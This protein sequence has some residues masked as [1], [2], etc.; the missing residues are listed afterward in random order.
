M[1]QILL[2]SDVHVSKHKDSLK[3]LQ[4]CLDALK[5]V[6]ETAVEKDI[7]NVVFLGDLFQDREKIQVL[8]YQRAY[9]VLA[10]YCGGD[11]PP[12][13]LYMII[14]NH[15]MWFLDKTNI[16]SV[17]PF[18]AL[19]GVRI[20]SEC[21]TINIAGLNIDFLPF[22]LN[23]LNSLESFVEG[24]SSVLCGHIALDGAQLNT[25]YKTYAD[26]SVEYDGEMMKV[27]AG[28]F[29][30]W[31]KVFLGHYHG[32]Q[33]IKNVEYVGSPLQINYAEANQE[34]HLI[35]LDT[36]TLEQEYVINTF[37]P[38]HLVISESDIDKYDLNNAFVKVITSSTSANVV[39]LR[40]QI[41]EKFNVESLDFSP[42]KAKDD[43]EVKVT[44]ENVQNIMVQD[45]DTLLKEY[46]KAIV[47][48]THLEESRLL[49][50]GKRFCEK[51]QVQ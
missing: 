3:K 21:K 46:L 18:G 49:E 27:D 23:P 22:T 29:K 20:I 15:D 41:T 17:Y 16:S 44:V 43:E 50:V 28:V 19:K 6:F 39:D 32:A 47:I 45:R 25:L 31:K 14:G 51:S 11:E 30:P 4:N 5:W 12:V 26:I 35:V 40:N 8:A 13:N 2:F 24:N 48:P 7:K 37:S 9:E 36:E 34:K 10:K 1:G 42:P 33:V 38:I